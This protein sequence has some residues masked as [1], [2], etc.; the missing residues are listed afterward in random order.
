[1]RAQR[2]G[3]LADRDPGQQQQPEQRADEQQRRGD[4]GG[5]PVRQRPADGEADEPGGAPPRFGVSRRTRPQV[6]QAEHRQ[7][8]Q[9][10]AQDQPRPR[11]GVG[12]GPHQRYR[13]GGGDHRQQ[14]DTPS[15]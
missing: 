13:D 7:R 5:Q 4:P 1:M 15:R 3:H 10:G 8:D 9:A 2:I 11:I 6:A 14:H 12:L